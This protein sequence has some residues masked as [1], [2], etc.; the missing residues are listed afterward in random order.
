MTAELLV[1]TVKDGFRYYSSISGD[2]WHPADDAPGSYEWWYF[3]AISDDGR[4][5]LVIIFLADFVFSPRFNRAVVKHRWKQRRAPRPAEFP[6]VSVCLYRDG[7][8][9][10]RA[11]SEYTAADFSAGRD[12]PFCRIGRS[13]FRLAETPQ[14]CSYDVTIDEHLRGGRR[15]KASL[16]WAVTDGDFASRDAGGTH[17]DANAPGNSDGHQWNMVAPRCRVEGIINLFERNG[18]RVDER[19]FCG[20]GYHDHNR[21]RRWLPATVAAWQWGRAHFKDQTTA[22]FYRYRENAD[23]MPTTRLFVVRGGELADYDAQLKTQRV[24]RHHFGVRY[25]RSLEFMAE[26]ESKTISLIFSQRRVIEGSYFYLRFLADVVLDIGDGRTQRAQAIT[27][28]LAPRALHWRWL[29]WLT[30]MRIGRNGRSS[31]LK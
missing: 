29:D 20:A 19:H 8:L 10:F 4:D 25:P 9:R 3:D 21:D 23:E 2:V 26:A 17:A 16:S 13:E 7:R 15:V 18:A 11:N 14:G 1:D 30:N 5:A 6:A 28:H 24:R 31:F 12:Q 22:V 27:E